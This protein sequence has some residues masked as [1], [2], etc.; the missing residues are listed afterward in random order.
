M[1]LRSIALAAGFAAF[2]LAPIPAMARDKDID[3]T[4]GQLSDPRTQT[5]AAA[6]MAAFSEALLDIKMAPFARAMD[7]AG[8]AAGDREAARSIDPDATL[9]EMLG[10]EAAR[11]PRELSAKVPEMMGAMAGM[12][13][14]IEAMVPE[15][16]AMARRLSRSL[17]RN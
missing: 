9:G 5:A 17:P 13:G 15:L 4:I 14:A 6:A 3:R 11:L 2:A 8:G 7:A 10:P 12:A 1:K 16:E